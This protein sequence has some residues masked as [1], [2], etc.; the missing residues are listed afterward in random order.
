LAVEILFY[1]GDPPHL[2]K[3]RARTHTLARTNFYHRTKV[4]EYLWWFGG[5]SADMKSICDKH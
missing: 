3:P 2:Y 4:E 1:S 5:S